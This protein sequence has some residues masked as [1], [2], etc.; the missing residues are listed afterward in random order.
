M[1]VATLAGFLSGII[2]CVGSVIMSTNNYMMFLDIPSFL[3]VGG[4]TLAVA[5][6]SFEPKYVT[7]SL[8]DV[9]S[10]LFAH[11]E[12]QSILKNE[13][14]R[15]IRWGYIVQRNG[16]KGL[17]TDAATTVKNDTFMVFGIDLVTAGYTGDEIKKI[18]ESASESAYKR[19]HMRSDVLKMMASTSPAFGMIGTLVGLIIM[20]GNLNDPSAIGPGMAVALITTLYGILAARLLFLPAATK[21]NQREDIVLFRNI[22]IA[23]GLSML[24][25]RR[26]PRYIQDRM[27]AYI[28]P[29]E[30]FLIDRDLQRKDKEGAP[31]AANGVSAASPASPAASAQSP[32]SSSGNTGTPS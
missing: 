10:I 17:E 1:S 23:E 29:N 7:G 24:A 25:E 15:I 12:G 20:L 32:A 18:L 19:A 21:V 11:R 8:Q 3:M 2:L 22:L 4:G 16:L 9:A 28:S 6:I 27:N 31:A 5:F 30:H 26:S 14:G 13:V